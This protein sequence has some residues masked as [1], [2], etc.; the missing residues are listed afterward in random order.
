MMRLGGVMILAVLAAASPAFSQAAKQP[1]TKPQKPSNLD[2]WMNQAK[3]ANDAKQVNP[4]DKGANP[5][6]AKDLPFRREDALPGVLELSDGRIIV[7]GLYTTREKPWEIW[8]EAEKRWRQIPFLNCLSLNAVVVEEKME[9]RWRWK[10]MGV[11]EKVFT[12][13]EYPARI[14]E[15]KLHL[16]DGAYLQGTVKGQPIYCEMP[17]GKTFG[18]MVVHERFSG[19][20]GQTLKDAIYIKRVI[21]SRRLY[22]KL[23]DLYPSSQPAE[24]GKPAPVTQTPETNPAPK[25]PTAPKIKTA[26]PPIDD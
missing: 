17:N 4:L 26:K 23:K 10:E 9:Q 19:Q 2:Y 15:W 6:A 20:D 22:D 3:P 5:F 18:P 1:A 11:P 25:P 24:A 12:G 7:G 13:K 16:I 21:V 14:F 8:V